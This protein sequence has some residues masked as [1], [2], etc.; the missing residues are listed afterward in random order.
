MDA[1]DGEDTVSTAIKN[2]STLFRFAQK[3]SYRDVRRAANYE[4]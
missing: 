2:M 4:R 3:W 1:S